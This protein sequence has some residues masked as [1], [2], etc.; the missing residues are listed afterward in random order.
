MS[1]EQGSSVKIVAHAQWGNTLVAARA[2][3]RGEVLF[4][5]KPF[6]VAEKDLGSDLIK[7]DQ[8]GDAIRAGLAF[9]RADKS[10]RDEILSS[11]H[12]PD[13]DAFAGSSAVKVHHEQ[14]LARHAP[15]FLRQTRST[16][17]PRHHADM[18]QHGQLPRVHGD[19][20]GWRHACSM[21]V[22]D[23]PLLCRMQ[24][25]EAA[26]ALMM[27]KANKVKV[28]KQELIKG[29]V[30]W[31][32]NAHPVQE[33]SGLFKQGSKF[34]HTCS[35]PNVR[36]VGDVSA[37]PLSCLTP[38]VVLTVSLAFHGVSNNTRI[39]HTQTPA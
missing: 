4:K 28:S 11:F 3:K 39:A 13:V 14:K 9:V 17:Y 36:C 5:E 8:H 30:T 10:T 19:M 25:A 24:S 20:H 12:T 15:L 1:G 6:I 29:I 21:A 37:C 16:I 35:H 31:T 38:C 7:A 18:A 26:A 32:T 27:E 33:G 34:A 2:I 22:L 23:T